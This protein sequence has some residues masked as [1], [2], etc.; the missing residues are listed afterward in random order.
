MDLKKIYEEYEKKYKLP[1]YGLLD[2]EFELLSVSTFVEINYPL[3]FIRRRIVDKIDYIMG[4]LQEILQ[5]DIGSLVSLEES[6]FFSDEDKT[7]IVEIIKKLMVFQR[8]SL[9][10]DVEFNLEDDV[11]FILEVFELWMKIKK[12]ISIVFTDFVVGWKKEIKEEKKEHY[13]G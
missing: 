1:K 4:V 9:I 5:P 8:R 10:L 2:N 11:R 7:K 13:I 12:E 6:K 3:R